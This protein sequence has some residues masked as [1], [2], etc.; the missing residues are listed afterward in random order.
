MITINQVKNGILKLRIVGVSIIVSL[1]VLINA[2]YTVNAGEIAMEQTPSGKLIPRMDPGIKFKIPFVSS[3]NFYNQV[4]TVTYQKKQSDASSSNKPF[5]ITFADTYSGHV[6]GSFRVEMPQDPDRFISLHKA[7]KRSDNFVDNGIEKFTNEL[8]AYTA[9]QFT[10]ETYMQGGQNEYKSRLQ[11]QA[12]N[13]LY[14][15]KRMTVKVSKQI[16]NVGLKND[17]PTKSS[18]GDAVIYKNVIQ[19]DKNGKPLRNA[20][21]M[22]VYGV[23]VSQV[24]IDGFDP[25]KQLYTFMSNK[26]ARVQERAT[27]I[28]NQEN[29][30]QSAITAKLK[31]DRERV[32]AK[33]K[34]LK[35]KDS[36][37]IQAQKKVEL[38]QKE[39]D[40]Q[41]VKKKK[42]LAISTANEGIQKANE[43]AAKYEAQAILHKG[44]AEAQVKKA[45]YNAID[46]VIFKAEVERDI[47]KYKYTAL[48][49]VKVEMPKT[50]IMSG[51][52]ESGSLQDL[53]NL[54]VVDKIGNMK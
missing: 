42:E 32:Q 43:K 19:R 40:L 3:V 5:H 13:G 24:T 53:T 28:E 6:K 14:V 21:P 11:D 18:S 10:G 49:K 12:Q 22:S 36:A 2:M 35:E 15:T 38:E 29:E 23:T 50:V 45:K 31:G 46:K 16:A 7:F 37:V 48:P 27:L 54:T 41:I 26:K 47:S 30:R 20:N 25:E 17:D 33:Q 4:Y 39:A 1:F 44:L 9:N 8:L 51:D 52:S 34:M